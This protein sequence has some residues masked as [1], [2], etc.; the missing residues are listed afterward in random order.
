[1]DALRERPDE[2]AVLSDDAALTAAHKYKRDYG[3]AGFEFAMRH[4]IDGRGQLYARY[5]PPRPAEKPACIAPE[6]DRPAVARGMCLMHYKRVRAGKPL[7]VD[8]HGRPA[9]FGQYGV[10]DRDEDSV[11]C[12][13]C[14]DRFPNLSSHVAAHGLTA[15]EY[16]QRYGLPLT[17]GMLS[18]R[19]SRQ[20]SEM[21]KS[22]VDT[23]AWRRLEAARDPV[24]ASL[25]RTLE[26]Y[27]AISVAKSGPDGQALARS[28]GRA[29]RRY[30]VVQCPVCAAEWCPV[31][32]GPNAY[33][34]LTCSADC[35]RSLMRMIRL[36][37]PKRNQA[38]DRQIAGKW[39][40]GLTYT[41]LADQYGVTPERIGQLIRDHLRSLRHTDENA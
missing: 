34:T 30:Q 23:A 17:K 40:A 26:S 9:G 14:G 21:S 22:Y 3:P 16:K 12:H 15:R 18:L 33:R 37:A 36:A 7:E 27:E 35:W 2:W 6:C 10:L 25:S 28:N 20:R 1:M 39:E 32:Y 41:D 8:K 13:E 11:L 19:L 29:A 24:A 31:P 5:A 38:R 4:I